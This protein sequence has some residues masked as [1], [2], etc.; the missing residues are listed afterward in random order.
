VTFPK[1]YGASRYGGKTATFDVNVREVAGPGDIQID[2]TLA[3]QV[4]VESL[5]K[6]RQAMRSQLESRYGE[7]ARQRAKRQVLDRLDEIHNFEL[8]PSMVAQEFDNIWRQITA[9]MQ[10]AE[11]SFEAEGTTETAAREEYQKIA[12]RRVRL[13]LVM[14]EL[15]ERNRIEVT[16]EEVQRALAAQLRQVPGQEQQYYDYYRQ[17]P[18]ALAALRAP[19]FEEK[20]VDFLLELADVTSKPMTKEELLKEAE[21]D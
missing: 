16:E 14:S 10:Q 3:Q 19:I 20:V 12:E 17:N 9:D 13:G 6:L 5:D 8:P 4:G 11:Q 7:M 2:D 18:E 1:D 21:T 15:G